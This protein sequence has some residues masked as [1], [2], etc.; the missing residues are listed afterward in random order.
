[1][2]LSD[3]AEDSLRAAIIGYLDE[4]SPLERK[5]EA[6]V[7]LCGSISDEATISPATLRGIGEMVNDFLTEKRIRDCHFFGRAIEHFPISEDVVAS[8]IHRLKKMG[9][10]S[11]VSIMKVPP[12]L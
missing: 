2:K 5:L 1:M 8:G 3:Q 4:S 7:E 11:V 9:H 6:L 12:M 10:K